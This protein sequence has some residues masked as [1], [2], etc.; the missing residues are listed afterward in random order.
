MKVAA[1][2]KSHQPLNEARVSTSRKNNVIWVRKRA[3]VRPL[4]RRADMGEFAQ[5]T[6]DADAFFA[7]CLAGWDRGTLRSLS[8]KLSPLAVEILLRKRDAMIATKRERPSTAN[9]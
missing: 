6:L 4:P 5:A 1:M 3:Q 9:T 2:A 8:K 7:A